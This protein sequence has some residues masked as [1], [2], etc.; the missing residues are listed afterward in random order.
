MS[1]LGGSKLFGKG[2]QQTTV[3]PSKERVNIA[4]ISAFSFKQRL[5]G[6]PNAAI[7]SVLLI[8]SKTSKVQTLI[9]QNIR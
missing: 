9:F 4:I 6:F 7:A 8:Y 1:K 5:L 3:V 2:Y